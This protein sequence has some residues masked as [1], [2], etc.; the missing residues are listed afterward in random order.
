MAVCLA[1]GLDGIEK[2]LTP[3]DE[4]TENI[5]AMDRHAREERGI[6]SLPGTLIEA[7][8]CLKE[9]S[10]ICDALG[11]H[12]LTQYVEGK[13]KEWDAYRT[14]VSRWEIDRYIVMY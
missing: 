7:V 5:F 13:L 4:I 1:A 10:V 6:R 11:E 8:E 14:H 2:K 12:V 9:D 3:P